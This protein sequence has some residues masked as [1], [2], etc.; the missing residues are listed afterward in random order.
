MLQQLTI[1]N[2]LRLGFGAILVII[3]ALILAA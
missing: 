2:K 1:A 3:L